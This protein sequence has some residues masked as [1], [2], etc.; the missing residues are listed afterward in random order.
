MTVSYLGMIA[1]N[2]FGC[3]CTF[4]VLWCVYSL[5]NRSM[6]HGQSGCICTCGCLF[7]V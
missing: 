5:S 2:I 3:I 4:K 1:I 7:L 6:P